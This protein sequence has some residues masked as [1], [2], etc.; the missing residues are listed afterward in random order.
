MTAWWSR[1]VPVAPPPES[2]MPPDVAPPDAVTRDVV[3]DHWHVQLELTR[4][5]LFLRIPEVEETVDSREL[6]PAISQECLNSGRP[7]FTSAASLALCAKQFDD[8]LYAAIELAGQELKAPLLR[9]LAPH[10]PLVA[11]AASLGGADIAVPDAARRRLAEFLSNDLHS[12][13]IGFYTW[14]ERLR[15]IFQQDRFL[16][17][18]MSKDDIAALREAFAGDPEMWATYVECL[19]RTERL[20]NA[21]ADDQPD[22]RR[23]GGVALFPPSRSHE[24]DLMQRLFG[25]RSIPDGF[26]LTDEL[27]KR[28]RD[29][30][31][32]VEPT[33][34]S[35]W[36]DHLTWAIAPLAVPERMPEASRLRLH[37]RYRDH[38]AELF[39]AIL[40]M[41]RETHA[42][43]LAPVFVGAA[44][45]PDHRREVI[46]TP[47]LSVEP[48]Q[49]FYIR[50]AKTYAWVRELLEHH[51]LGHVHRMTPEGQVPRRL[52]EELDEMMALFEGA[53]ATVGEELGVASATASQTAVFRE[54]A[55]GAQASSDVRMMV[56]VY[57]DLERRTIRVWAILGWATR[58]LD[59]NWNTVPTTRVLRGDV[60]IRWEGTQVELPYPVFAEANVT[61]VMDREEFRRHCDTHR[62]REEILAHL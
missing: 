28:L 14:D 34:E 20:T 48:T 17:Q 46:I 27:L 33:T 32:S 53:A 60:R 45:G 37:P 7:R 41:T 50:R 42:K 24:T 8:G 36:Y 26:S 23:A 30:S 62:T 56:P 49:S 57:Y 15:R 58:Q 13:P 3:S 40:S 22:L 11:A 35:G 55:G 52:D 54:W 61:R 1:L 2:D 44:G 51:G 47:D 25:H 6:W 39:K 18:S 21:F 16:Q 10:A 19:E 4:Q 38:L 59:V 43:Q 29:G 31:L 12:K 5:I 9:R